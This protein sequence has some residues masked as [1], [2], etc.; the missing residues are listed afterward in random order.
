VDKQ[1]CFLYQLQWR[2]FIPGRYN[3][4]KF[5]RRNQY[6]ILSFVAPDVETATG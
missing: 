6:G 4:C 1:Q 5:Y 2:E 3:L